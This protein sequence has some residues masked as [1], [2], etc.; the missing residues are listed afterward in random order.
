MPSQPSLVDLRSNSGTT[1]AIYIPAKTG[2]IFVLDRRDGHQLVPAPEK[3]VPQGAAPGDRLSP[4]QPFSGLSFRPP[5][6]L[7]GAE[8]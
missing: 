2:D 5:G 4:T 8:M 3:P 6:V 7:T 1:P